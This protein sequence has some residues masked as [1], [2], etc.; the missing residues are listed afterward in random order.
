M[1]P[2]DNPSQ[3][4]EAA[5]WRG[6]YVSNATYDKGE[7]VFYNGS[8]YICLEYDVTGVT[9]DDAA[10]E[11][12]LLA[13]AGADG[14]AGSHPDLATHDT[15]GLATD[16]ELAAHTGDATDAHDASAISF[17]PAG[18]IAATDVQAAIEEV[19]SEAG[20]GAHPDLATHDALGLATDAELTTHAGL[21]THHDRSH[22]HSAAGDGQTLLPVALQLPRSITPD[23][24]TDGYIQWDQDD[25][26]ISVGDGVATKKFYP[27]GTTDPVTQ[28]FGD[29][30]A[31]GTLFETARVDH[32]HGMPANPVTAHESDATDAHDASA[33]SILD[34]ANDFTA[35]DVEGALAEL[36]SDAETHAA[37]ADPHTGYRL[38][39]ADHTHASTGLQGGTVD[40][41]ALTGLGDD[42]HP[43]YLTPAE[44]DA[45]YEPLGVALDEL[46]DVDTTGAA[47]GKVLKH[48]GTSWVVGDDNVGAGGSAHVIKEAGASLT[49]RA[50]LNF[51]AGF[52]IADDAAND[53]TDV[54]LDL[55][56]V[57]ILHSSLGGITENDHHSRAHDHSS[58]ND[59]QYLAPATLD[60]PWATTPAQTVE[61]RVIWDS[62]GDFLTVGD[63]TARKTLAPIGS[64]SPSTQ[65]FGDAAA[66]GSANESAKVDHKHA[67][68][69]DPVTAHAAAADPHTGY[70]LESA[71]HTHASTG[72]QAGTIDHGVLTGLGD[73]DHTQYLL[74]TAAVKFTIGGVLLDPTAARTIEVWR[75]PFS[76]TITGYRAR[77][78]GGTNAVT[79]AQVDAT[80]ILTGDLTTAPADGWEA[81]T[82][83]SDGT[84]NVTAGEV[85]KFEVVSVSGAVTE[86]TWQLELT[87][88][89]LV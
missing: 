20:A 39:S 23:T 71:D 21:A 28:A 19:A 48:N 70:R 57:T 41:G 54:A 13:Q 53:E 74:E 2:Q 42:D 22:D 69:A 65:A 58:A 56:E 26:H 87:R 59:G 68:P 18:T 16:A 66:S 46:T 40:H 60:L 82:V 33:I 37:A 6:T 25:N 32:K 29:A 15:L 10:P 38:E 31:D 30:P 35:T 61:G 4:N 55:S 36:Q 7:A 5:W 49:Q 27:V 85:I 79:N 75:A 43:Q 81:G 63:G 84:E 11:W 14:A 78:V 24:T 34:A 62:D 89:A 52:D 77:V 47:N 1:K 76:C 64:T 44:A 50:G 45:L 72:A 9:P 8:S 86:V 51:G 3:V 80:D 83:K 12:A 67:M 73:D 88:A 17:V